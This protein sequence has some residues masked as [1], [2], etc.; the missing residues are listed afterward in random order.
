MAQLSIHPC[1]RDDRLTP[2]IGGN[3]PHVDHVVA[4]ANRDLASLQGIGCLLNSLRLTGQR[5]FLDLQ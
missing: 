2:T 3:R 5:R 1:C 4:V